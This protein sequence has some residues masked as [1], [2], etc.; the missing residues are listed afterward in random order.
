MKK[1][2]CVLFDMDGTLVESESIYLQLWVEVLA[3]HGFQVEVDAL[4]KMK[5]R[6]AQTNNQLI[7]EIIQNKAPVQALRKEREQL[8]NEAIDTGRIHLKKGM[9]E[10]LTFL[11]TDGYNLGV[12]TMSSKK[13]AEHI[14]KSNGVRDYFAEL[15][16]VET[17]KN[18]KPAPDIYLNALKSPLFNE[19][20][21]LALEDTTLGCQAALAAG[22]PVI[23]ISAAKKKLAQTFQCQDGFGV[24]DFLRQS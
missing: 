14:L 21:A 8:V 1:Y 6:D 5:G 22:I 17:V 23:L 4:A 19:K 9:Q 13:R 24:I 16:T 15:V 12:A 11:R 3:K 18:P 20:T 2:D 10:L 7:A